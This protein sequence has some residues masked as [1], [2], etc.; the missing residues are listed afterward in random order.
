[1]SS[2]PRPEGE[3]Y[4][5]WDHG[6][7][8]WWSAR[9]VG[10]ATEVAD[11]GRYLRQYAERMARQRGDLIAVPLSAA[12]RDGPPVESKAQAH[13]A[14]VLSGRESEMDLSRLF[15]HAVRVQGGDWSR[16]EALPYEAE[17]FPTLA[18]VLA[19]VVEWGAETFPVIEPAALAKHLAREAAELAADPESTEEMA[20]VLILLAQIAHHQG[21]SLTEAVREKLAILRT[22]EWGEPDADGVIEHVRESDPVAH[23]AHYGGEADPYEAIKVIEAW[24]L[25]FH[26]GNTLKYIRRAGLKGDALED[27]RKSRWYLDRLIERGGEPSN[28][29]GDDE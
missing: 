6:V 11:A 8:Q 19:E 22:R 26:L 21:A 1:M 27:L 4:L 29:G 17:P 9:S 13:S 12:L 25:D 24:G 16:A 5:I 23:P 3:P 7:G 18:G 15:Q 14:P 28:G 10:H 20:D 2:E